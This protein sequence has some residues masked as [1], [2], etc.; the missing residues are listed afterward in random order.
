MSRLTRLR[1]YGTALDCFF[2][3]CSVFPLFCDT[4]GRAFSF[5]HHSS[6]ISMASVLSQEGAPAGVGDRTGVR[7]PGARL[8]GVAWRRGSG[9]KE[10][11]KALAAEL[12]SVVFQ[13]A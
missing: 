1:L 3:R 10:E 8:R 13:A 5:Y 9:R 7:A 4:K 2:S 6:E 11:A 12:K